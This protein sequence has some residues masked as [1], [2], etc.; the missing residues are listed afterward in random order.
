ME[1]AATTL[2]GTALVGIYIVE[3]IG[4]VD[5]HQSYH[6]QEDTY[7]QTGRALHVEGI[8][9]LDFCPRV[10]AFHETETVDGGVAQHER[11]AELECE[12]IVGIRVVR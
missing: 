3:T 10:T 6:R 7:T 12:A 2:L 1:V 5:T 9:L 8:E 4:P 11:I